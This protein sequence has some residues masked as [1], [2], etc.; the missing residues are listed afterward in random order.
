MLTFLIAAHNDPRHLS[1]LIGSLPGGSRFVV[2]IDGKTDITPFEQLLGGRSDVCFIQERVKVMWGSICHVDCQM[3]MIRKAL[4]LHAPQ[5]G[6]YFVM[7]SGLDYPLWSNSRI[8]KF[9]AD[10]QGREI[11][12]TQCMEHQGSQADIYRQHRPLNYKPWK[13]GSM[14]SK[15]R[16]ALR[17]MLWALGFRK[18]LRFRA[19]GSEYVLYK[20]SM[21]WAI[22]PDLAQLAL[23][24]WDE[25][26]EYVRYFHDGHGPDET[27]IQTITAHSEF[28]SRAIIVDGPFRGMESV[29]PLHY[30][31]Y[32]HG[33]KVFTAADFQTLI[34]SGKMFCRKVTT[35]ESSTLLDMIDRHRQAEEQACL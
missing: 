24:Y 34:D 28:A 35:A 32:A 30:V 14:K 13:Y 10:A 31:D 8:S 33:T 12:V 23:K 6:D 16:V 22:T 26:P 4:E 18:P 1:R 2:H 25:K 29:T 27:F 3:R 19:D 20:G 7:L 15:F 21:N 17:K 5:E 9:F 11:I